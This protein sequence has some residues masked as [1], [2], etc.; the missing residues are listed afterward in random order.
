[1]FG[2]GRFTNRLKNGSL[3]RAVSLCGP[4][5]EVELL[6]ARIGLRFAAL[7]REDIMISAEG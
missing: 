7:Q 4:L 6:L 3:L 1:V 2:D 5:G